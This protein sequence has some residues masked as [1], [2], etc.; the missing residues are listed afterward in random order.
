MLII[1]DFKYACRLLAKKPGF[2]VLTILVMASGIGLSLF[3]FSFFHNMLFK[4]LPF[5]DGESLV[6]VNITHKGISKWFVIEINYY[7]EVRN[8]L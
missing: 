3:L 2:S 6:Q 4:D 8:I 5:K 7:Y 1:S